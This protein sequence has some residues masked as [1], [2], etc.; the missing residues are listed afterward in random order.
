M[1]GNK[2]YYYS[3]IISKNI[4]KFKYLLGLDTEQFATR[5]GL[6]VERTRE[7]EDGK[8]VTSNGIDLLRIAEGCNV[9]YEDVFEAEGEKI[10]SS[11]FNVKFPPTLFRRI[12]NWCDRKEK[13]RKWVA[14]KIGVGKDRI[15]QWVSDRGSPSPTVFS[16]LIALLNL[17]ACD[18]EAMLK[19]ESLNF[20]KPHYGGWPKKVI[21]EEQKP[22]PEPKPE[23]L[24]SKDSDREE[25][26]LTRE[27]IAKA[28]EETTQPDEFETRM[29]KVMRL[30][31]DI[32]S[33]MNQA[34]AIMT[35]AYDLYKQLEKLK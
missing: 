7:L 22:L 34:K 24:K 17:R 28:P 6:S 25:P 11:G 13:T 32:D 30:Q 14:E 2:T 19:D 21:K 9:R 26:A 3:K 29:L 8:N 35:I 16:N 31:K 10:V 33:L 5:C 23:L 18:L 20:V 4:R 15:S 1:K 12:D 27:D